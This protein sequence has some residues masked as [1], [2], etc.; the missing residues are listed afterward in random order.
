[1]KYLRTALVLALT[2]LGSACRES[3]PTA[4]PSTPA[5]RPAASTDSIA[6]TG[7]SGSGDAAPTGSR[8]TNTFGSGN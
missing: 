5:S 7:G 6:V 2:V 4:V 8:G 3:V 1:M